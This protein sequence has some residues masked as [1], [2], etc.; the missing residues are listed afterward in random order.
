[1]QRCIVLKYINQKLTGYMIAAYFHM[2]T[3]LWL[4]SNIL[5]YVVTA[6]IIV[7]QPISHMELPNLTFRQILPPPPYPLFWNWCV[8]RHPAGTGRTFHPSGKR[9]ASGFAGRQR[10]KFPERDKQFEADIAY[11]VT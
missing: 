2:S 4:G 11:G 1:M 5:G 10:K 8:E 6:L 7:M 9:S 3:I